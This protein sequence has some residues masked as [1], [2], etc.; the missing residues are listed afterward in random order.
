[1]E[2]GPL[3]KKLGVWGAVAVAAF[4]LLTVI[5]R[6]VGCEKGEQVTDQI[7]DVATSVLPAEEEPKA[8]EAEEEK[9]DS[10]EPAKEEKPAD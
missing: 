2:T 3:V 1:M 7:L 8:E 9:A 10:E 6:A 4:A 5:F